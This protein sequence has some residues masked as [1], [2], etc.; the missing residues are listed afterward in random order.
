M[1]VKVKM[2]AEDAKKVAKGCL[3]QSKKYGLPK[4]KKK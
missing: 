3:E 2:S 4:K 1:G